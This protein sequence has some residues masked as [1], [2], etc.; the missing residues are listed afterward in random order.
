MN[1]KERTKLACKG[2][3]FIRQNNTGSKWK[4]DGFISTIRRDRTDIGREE[5]GRRGKEEYETQKIEESKREMGKRKRKKRRRR[6]G[7][8]GERKSLNH[9]VMKSQ[10]AKEQPVLAL[11]SPWESNCNSEQFKGS[12][13]RTDTFRVR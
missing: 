10:T 1:L 5:K 13:V 6:E 3:D 9:F 7:G 2:C 12:Q 8:K 11:H 4:E